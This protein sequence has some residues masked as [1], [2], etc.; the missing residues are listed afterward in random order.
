[1]TRES[2][3]FIL[4]VPATRWPAVRR[5]ISKAAGVIVAFYTFVLALNLLK[6]G[7]TGVGAVL[8]G[9][10]ASGFTNLLGFGWLAAHLSLSGSPVAALSLS[11]F[12]GG[13]ISALETLGMINGSR[14]GASFIVLVAGFIYY[15]RGGQRGRGVIS[16][17]ILSMLTTATVYLPA[18]FIAIRLLTSGV[19][20]PVRF[21]SSGW[22]HSLV[23]VLV[24]PVLAQLPPSVPH[25][26]LFGAGYAGLLL[27]S[28]LFDR[29]LPHM[30]SQDLQQGRLG[31]WIYRPLTMFAVGM[32]VTSVTLSVSLSLS[33][34]VPLAARG[35]VA[36][37]QV[38]P[39]I[40]GANITTFID[41]LFVALL[42]ANPRAFTI[43]LAEMIS[44]AA[45]SLFILLTMFP[46]YQRAL[47]AV[48]SSV[49]STKSRFALFVG[50]IALVPLILLLR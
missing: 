4:T 31:A 3:P 47:L 19:L 30:H 15:M 5:R 43:V 46:A 10:S 25:L 28:R 9:V 32:L 17:G 38:I 20:D 27:S 13:A 50:I 44:V 8:R 1:M 26:A 23:D 16:M 7:A 37:K 42:I 41:T 34:L 14:L 33:L 12:G 39:Y 45:V 11:L 49:A 29:A 24:G 21:G 18:M 40:M 35:L 36:R 6:S 48:N 2:A 22:S